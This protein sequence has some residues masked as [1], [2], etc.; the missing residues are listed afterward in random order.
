MDFLQF[1]NKNKSQNNTL[2]FKP[3]KQEQTQEQAYPKGEKYHKYI[4]KEVCETYV[5]FKKGDFI[6]IVYVKDSKL[7][8]YKG[9]FGEIRNY[10]RGASHAFVTLEA[11][12]S[13]QEILFPITHFIKRNF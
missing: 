11:V 13:K 9:Y 3:Q 10:T 2:I 5:E 1:L 7:N 4:E 8:M 12:N 6:K